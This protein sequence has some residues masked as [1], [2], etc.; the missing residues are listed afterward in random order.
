[1]AHRAVA[2]GTVAQGAVALKALDRAR[3]TPK[4]VQMLAQEVGILP[5]P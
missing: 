5:Y 1:M 2:Q 3:L 4:A